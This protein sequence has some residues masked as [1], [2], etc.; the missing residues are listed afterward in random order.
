[1]LYQILFALG[2]V[3]SL[4]YE[5]HLD[6]TCRNTDCIDVEAPLLPPRRVPS[7]LITIFARSPSGR[8][9]QRGRGLSDDCSRTWKSLGQ[10]LHSTPPLVTNFRSSLNS[11]N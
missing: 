1:V 5:F 7:I 2:K 6:Q 4:G 9:A 11:Q 10:S 8:M 3:T